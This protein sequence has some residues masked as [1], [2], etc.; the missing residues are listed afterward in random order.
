MGLFDKFKEVTRKVSEVEN[1][2]YHENR[3]FI[4]SDICKFRADMIFIECSVV[5]IS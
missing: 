4:S 1:S 3:D 2:I 5:H